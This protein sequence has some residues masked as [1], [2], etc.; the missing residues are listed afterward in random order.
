MECL[1]LREIIPSYFDHLVANPSSLL[2]IFSL[3]LFIIHHFSNHPPPEPTKTHMHKKIAFIILLYKFTTIGPILWL[4]RNPHPQH[5]QK[6]LFC[7][8][9]QCFSNNKKNAQKIRFKRVLGEEMCRGSTQNESWEGFFCFLFYFVL[10]CFVLFCFD[11]LCLA[12]SCFA[13]FCFTLLCFVFVVVV[14]QSFFFFF[15]HRF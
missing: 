8:Y 9:E 15:L 5:L 14:A 11:L 4:S 7:G 12:L 10:F 1:L 13:L 3:L 6:P 2:V